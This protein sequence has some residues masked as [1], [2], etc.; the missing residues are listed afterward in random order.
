MGR[1][2]VKNLS[3]AF[4]RYPSP[5]ARLKEWLLPGREYHEKRWVLQGLDFEV[6][7]GETIGLVGRNGAGK[8]T[9]L[10][11]LTGTLAANSG[12]IL[13]EG[14]VAALL[15]LGMGFH[16]DFTGRQNVYMA[17]QLLGLSRTDIDNLLPAIVAFAEI[18]DALD[19]PVRTYSSGMQVR[20]AFSVATAVRPDILIVDE[21]LAV[22]D[23]YF[24]HKCFRR[25]REFKSQGVTLLFVSHDPLAVKSLCNRAILIEKGKVVMD[26]EPDQVLDY[27]N[28]L[29]AL[30]EKAAD[31]HAA[32]ISQDT[33]MTR[34][35]SGQ[36]RLLKVDL[37][38]ATGSTR[39]LRHGETARL[40][41][42]CEVCETI[43]ELTLGFMLRDRL[44]NEIFGTNTFHAEKTLPT[45]AGSCFTVEF[46]LTDCPLGPGSFNATFALHSA[47]NHLNGNYDWWDQALTFEV[48]QGE[49][50]LFSGVVGLPVA[51]TVSEPSATQRV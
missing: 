31:E 46:E 28:A 36:A 17:G 21:A 2:V 48:A 41:V 4:R 29:I 3:K 27:Y 15:E 51:I 6:G 9:L 5:L 43:P 45:Q 34:S 22:G 25:I 12:E 8:S 42:D 18:G 50:A 10:K 24:Q 47:Y 26:G 11:M 37:Q 20:L 16:P 39:I 44:G 49:S 19:Q 14:R 33:S 38:N 40:V 32:H 13:I 1:I 30:D 35:G 23:A 7:A